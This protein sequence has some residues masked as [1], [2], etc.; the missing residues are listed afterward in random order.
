[1][2]CRPQDRPST[3]GKKSEDHAEKSEGAELSSGMT[4]AG[5]E[6]GMELGGEGCSGA[7]HTCT[8]G[9]ALGRWASMAL[10]II[11]AGLQGE[12]EPCGKLCLCYGR[13][14]C[15]LDPCEPWLKG[16]NFRGYFLALGNVSEGQGSEELSLEEKGLAGDTF[17]T[18]AQLTCA[19]ACRSQLW[20]SPSTPT[21]SAPAFP[22]RL[23]PVCLARW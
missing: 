12:S 13:R 3:P 22:C 14:M 4:Q 6:R 21:G 18:P 15:S 11:G 2:T 10:Q 17:P 19:D 5:L 1:M 9:P 23:D 20:N 7:W 8:W 16:S